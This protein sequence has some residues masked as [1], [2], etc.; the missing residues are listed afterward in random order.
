MAKNR[1]RFASVPGGTCGSP[2][3]QAVF[4]L[5]DEAWGFPEGVIAFFQPI[6]SLFQ[7]RVMGFE[8]LARV[9]T[10][11][12][13]LL[14]PRQ[15]LPFLTLEQRRELSRLMLSAGLQLLEQ[16]D[17]E[18]YCLEMSFN[19]DPDFMED[20]DCV[21]CFLGVLQGSPIAAQRITL[22]L[23]ESGDFL[24]G[25]IAVQR[26]E[27]LRETGAQ[28]ALDDIGSAYSSLLRLKN[29]P[30]QK[31]KLDQ[32]LVKDLAREP[33]IIAFV[34]SMK[35]LADGLGATLI[36]EGVE[37]LAILDA[38]GNLSQDLVQ[39]YAI[40]R[41]MDAAAF[42]QYLRSDPTFPTPE[43]PGS[44]LGA[45]AAHVLRRPL[46]YS[47]HAEMSELSPV[48]FLERSPLLQYLRLYPSLQTKPILEAYGKLRELDQQSS[49][50]VK[51]RLQ[52]IEENLQPLVFAAIR[53]AD[54][55]S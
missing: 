21:P 35:F 14:Q 11:S 33:K 3:T 55:E 49:Q 52:E 24:Q 38:M 30:I 51:Q 41:P 50:G 18:G 36:V 2:V 31:I 28:I 40:A 12:G 34:Q 37:T 20:R 53:A 16:L 7:Q 4:G 15:F 8:V 26:L 9:R 44:L 17:A 22:E 13:N 19:V 10:D 23:L 45:Y 1:S 5:P 27:H 29:L 42:V 54:E 32:E 39:G 43:S 25:D 48:E 46:L 6:Y 47:L